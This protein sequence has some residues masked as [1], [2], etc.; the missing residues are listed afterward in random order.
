MQRDPAQAAPDAGDIAPCYHQIDTLLHIANAACRT[1][2][3][4]GHSHTTRQPLHRTRGLHGML[5]ASVPGRLIVP[6]TTKTIPNVSSQ[7]GLHFQP[8]LFPPPPANFRLSC[9][10]ATAL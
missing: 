6:S 5:E 1:A 2:L 10:K 3:T 8:H 4:P 7:G 9:S